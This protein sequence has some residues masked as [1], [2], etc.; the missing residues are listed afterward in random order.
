LHIPRCRAYARVWP[1]RKGFKTMT[2]DASNRRGYRQVAGLAETGRY[3][4]ALEAIQRHLLDSPRDG[5]AFNDAGTILHALGRFDEAAE[6]L[7]RAI[8]LL[9]GPSAAEAE[10]NLVEVYLACDKPGEV[11]ALLEDLVGAGILTADLA[12]RSANHLLKFGDLAGAAEALLRSLEICPLQ[13]PLTPVV[14]NLRALRPKVAM[15][16]PEGPSQALGQVRD[17]LAR[18]FDVSLHH[19]QA[20]DDLVR[21][22]H[23]CDIAWFE[24]CTRQLVIASK[25]AKRWRIICRL[26]LGGAYGPWMEQTRWENVDALI[27]PPNRAILEYLRQRVGNLE[28][29]TRLVIIPD[30][31]DLARFAFRRR[32]AGKNLACI[33]RLDMRHNPM[34][35]LQCFHRLHAA[36]AASRLFFAGM[37]TDDRIEQYLHHAVARMGLSAAVSF[38]GYQEDLPAWLADKHYVVSAEVAALQ[39]TSVL[40]AMAAGLQPVV[41]DFPGAEDFLPPRSLYLTPEDFCR[42][43]LDEPYEPQACR[44]WVAARFAMKDTLTQINGLMRELEKMPP[45]KVQPKDSYTAETASNRGGG[46]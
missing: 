30:G 41:H 1:A 20:T 25:A 35:L 7:K 22:L 23:G 34:F 18:R 33:G 37:F 29:R 24:D 45:L 21:M 38:D 6:H 5:E 13:S 2:R 26:R 44:D 40:E 36:D 17:F 39:P 9:E 8:A 28:G 42:R 14:E 11:E 46:A 10:R 32:E 3:G 27:V 43:I 16:H 12:N 4:E 15:F 31:V 19:G